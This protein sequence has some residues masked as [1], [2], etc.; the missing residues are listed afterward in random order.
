[1]ERR[2]RIV[3]EVLLYGKKNLMELNLIRLFG[4][5]GLLAGIVHQMNS[6]STP[7]VKITGKNYMSIINSKSLIIY[8]FLMTSYVKN[9]F[10]HIKPT[11]TTDHYGESFLYNG[12]LNLQGCNINYDGN[13]CRM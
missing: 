6:N 12:T 5:T 1:M 7:T 2:V 8:F 11:L 13:S 3:L 9:G 4:N 10:L